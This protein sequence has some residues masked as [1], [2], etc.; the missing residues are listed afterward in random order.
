MENVTFGILNNLTGN[1]TIC[2]AYDYPP[3]FS[4]ISYGIFCP[5]ISFSSFICNLLVISIFLKQEK[6]SP[7]T[8]M[9]TA[10]AIS[11]IFAGNILS[12]L[13]IILYGINS[14]RG[15][16]Y[17]PYPLCTYQDYAYN[18]AA[19]FHMTSVWLTTALGVQRYIVVAYPLI[20][21]RL[22]N[23][24]KSIIA[25]FGCFVF[26]VFMCSPYFFYKSHEV[27][28]HIDINGDVEW[29][30]YCDINHW[31]V[32][33]LDKLVALSR[34][35]LGNLVPCIILVVTT[36][37]LLR[38]L[39][40]ETDR[41][42]Q[43]HADEKTEKMRKDF[44]HIKR[45]SQMIVWIVICFLFVEI[46]NGLFLLTKALYPDNKIMFGNRET[47]FAVI[48]ILNIFV[49]SSYFVNF[50]IFITLSRKFRSS[51]KK[52]LGLDKLIRRIKP[53]YKSETTTSS[54]PGTLLAL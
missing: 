25:I 28:R 7:T 47:I 42:L 9:L 53:S 49:F 2:T 48:S 41:I 32:D 3:L 34:C 26:S 14:G 30:C 22:C 43:L 5:I 19:V 12:P 18:F 27:F 39:R 11:D 21:P 38:K 20:G 10:L 23:I 15:A 8:V 31:M 33:K 44:R 4:Y 45:T 46:P 6:R 29:L 51:L 24:R 13:F 36:I 50:W 52:L 16:Y 37:L 40:N 17:L 1:R 35:I 54:S